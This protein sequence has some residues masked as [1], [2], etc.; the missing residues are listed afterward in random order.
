MN[1]SNPNPQTTFSQMK[2]RFPQADFALMERGVRQAAALW[3]AL[4]G[5][6]A[7]FTTFCLEQYVADAAERETLFHKLSYAQEVFGGGYHK[8]SVALAL[9]VQLEGPPLTPIDEL[10][11]SY[12]PAAHYKD[13]MFANKL[14]FITILNFPNFS[15][16]EKNDLGTHWSRLEWAYARMGDA[17]T[18]RLPASVAQESAKASSAANNYIAEYNIM[19]GHL[20]DEQGQRLFPS[21]MVLLSH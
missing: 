8:M 12:A 3:T 11:A 21:D 1:S 5:T 2:D 7:D 4:D 19:M 15:L 6:E 20:L 9:P 14:A 17:F 13:D 16:Q 10:L 18:N